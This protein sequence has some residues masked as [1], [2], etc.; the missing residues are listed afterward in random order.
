[1]ATRQYALTDEDRVA[2]RE[3]HITPETIAAYIQQFQQGFPPIQLDR[4][5]TVGDGITS[6]PAETARLAQLYAE[7]AAAGR[8][9]KFV[10]ASGA[11]SRMFQLPL[12]FFQQPELLPNQALARR[13]AEGDVDC[14]TF[15]RFLRPS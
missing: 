5:C 3:R 15:Q 14:Q 6:V 12:S 13:A 10:P 4:P 11:A 7:A 8:M 1:M 2:L 9:T